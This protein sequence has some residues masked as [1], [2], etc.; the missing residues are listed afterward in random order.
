MFDIFGLK[1]EKIEKIRKKYGK[2]AA[3]CWKYSNA[4]LRIAILCAL[5][6]L[7]IAVMYIPI[8]HLNDYVPSLMYLILLLLV[9]VA[10]IAVLAYTI[11]LIIL[12]V[13]TKDYGWAVAIILLGILAAWIYKYFKGGEL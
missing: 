11:I 7:I 1:D 2:T 6:S 4:A 9:M 3:D 12:S 8:T 13:L 10:G 5:I